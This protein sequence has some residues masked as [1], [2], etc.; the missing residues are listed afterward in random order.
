MARIDAG[1]L[2]IR[3]AIHQT[4]HTLSQAYP[5][6]LIYPLSVAAKD[7][8]TIKKEAAQA[9]LSSIKANHPLLVEHVALGALFYLHR[10]PLTICLVGKELIRISRSWLERWHSVGS[11]PSSQL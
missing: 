9:L 5:H 2:Y 4:L 1:N 6:A 8:G 3:K 10:C 7:V 11:L